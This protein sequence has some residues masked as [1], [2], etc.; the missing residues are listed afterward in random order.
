MAQ[1]ALRARVHN[2]VGV[3]PTRYIEVYLMMMNPTNGSAS[4]GASRFRVLFVTVVGVVRSWGCP[5]SKEIP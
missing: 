4:I 1:V 3:R 5:F 2:P